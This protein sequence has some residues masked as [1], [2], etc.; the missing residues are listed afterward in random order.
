MPGEHGIH[1][2]AER[3]GFGKI[4]VLYRRFRRPRIRNSVGRI[5]TGL[6]V[7]GEGG[8]IVLP[9][10]ILADGRCYRWVNNG[11]GT[12]A[13]APAWLVRLVLPPPPPPRSDP[14]PPPA[15]T[16]RYVAAA[17]TAELQRLEEAQEGTRNDQLNRS[18]FAI[19][20]FVHAGAVPDDWAR[21]EL[22]RRAVG[23][24]LPTHP[25]RP[26]IDSAFKAARP[27]EFP[28]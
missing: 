9:P 2:L 22:E 26:T 12:F 10:S 20:G 11:A 16:T 28:R 24:G 13:G 6:D 17:I 25:A 19:A 15:D 21:G 4:Q 1:D 3:R 7:R 18:A 8:S 27:R 14:K 23:I 5:G